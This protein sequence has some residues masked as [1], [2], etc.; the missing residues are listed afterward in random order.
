MV[1]EGN[2]ISV[3]DQRDREIAQFPL[4]STFV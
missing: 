4:A 3:R 2:F 1:R